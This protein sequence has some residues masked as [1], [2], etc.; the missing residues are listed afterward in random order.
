MNVFKQKQAL[1][2]P[3]DFKYNLGDK[4]ED[5]VTGFKG[6]LI[7]RTQWL[8]NCNTYSLQPRKLVDGS[9]QKSQVFDEPQLKLVKA[10]DLGLK[11]VE[12]EPEPE[13]TGG[14]ER[15]VTQPRDNF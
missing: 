9:P 14:P 5:V 8:N 7:A 4:V 1:G 10:D 12:G 3:H 15:A 11:Q 2:T 6:I 13:K